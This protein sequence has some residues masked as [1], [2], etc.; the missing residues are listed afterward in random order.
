MCS[1]QLR[2]GTNHGGRSVNKVAHSHLRGSEERKGGAGT[3]PRF[4]FFCFDS[5]RVPGSWIGADRFSIGLILQEPF[6]PLLILFGNAL[7]D[8]KVSLIDATGVS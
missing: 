6:S 7:T 1:R 3:Q 4:S 5:V 8:P 2:G